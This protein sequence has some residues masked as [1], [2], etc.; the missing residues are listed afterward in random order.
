VG[1]TIAALLW[2]PVLAYAADQL[3]PGQVDA[4]RIQAAVA[5]GDDWLTHG[6][7][8]AEDRHSPL[9]DINAETVNRL[10]LAWSY[11]TGTKRGLEATPIVVD[12]VLYA[13]GSWS[14]VFA[15]DAR[16]GRE[17]WRFDPEVPKH[18]GRNACC[19]VVNRGVAVWKGRVYVGTIDGRL[20][21]IDSATGR[22]VW[23]VLTVDPDR[24]YTITGAPRVVKDLVI[25]GNGGADLGVRGYFGAYDAATGAL[26]WRFY[27]V[28]ANK[29]GPHEHPELVAAAKTWPANALWES[30]L[31]GTAWDSMAYDPELDLL[32]VGTGNSSVY[33]GAVRSPGGGDNLYLASILAL[34]PETGRLVWHYQTT[35]GENWDYTATQQMILTDR[36]Y[37]GKK[38]K[39]L[40]QAPK[41]G[42]FYILDR[43]TGEL[44]SAEPYVPVSWATHVDLE[45]GRPAV[46]EEADWSKEDRVIAPHVMGA[47]SWH[48]MSFDANRGLVY[49]SNFELAYL[50]MAD[51]NF[52]YRNGEYN[53]GEDMAEMAR[54]A[55]FLEPT[56]RMYCTPSRLVAWDIDRQQKRWEVERDIITAAGVLSTAG[57][58]VFQGTID[59]EF[60]AYHA[61]TGE[62]LWSTDT[63]VG[64]MAA[65][66][67][68]RVDGEQYVAVLAG[69]GGAVG[70]NFA[71]IR[72][73][74]EGT[75]LAFKLGGAVPM[76]AVH[77]R[78]AGRVTVAR[79]DASRETLDRG[80]SLYGKHCMRCHGPGV[81]SSGLLPD[82]R[83]ASRE[84]HARWT[85]V[86]L[87]GTRAKDGMASFAD[88]IDLEQAQ[89]IQ[90]YVIERAY[91]EP[92]ALE[93]LIAWLP[94][95]PFCVRSSWV[96]D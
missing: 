2:L 32:Y 66:V 53:S 6:R 28:P 56:N 19:D 83:H 46:R 74:N 49:M 79:I 48:P 22:P 14:V 54:L 69:A 85:D 25:I 44:L 60:S 13:T 65:P 87:G 90:S 59:G 29:N 10:G 20:I 52:E 23:D 72:N 68:Y 38:R 50:F 96:T 11:A 89:A 17:I 35:P 4:A 43:E 8:Y 7:T 67:T 1:C 34:R 75:L 15:L 42:F 64:I 55:E 9:R 61:D 31:G 63:G 16:T 30:G 47:H 39:L 73:T 58:L 40:L 77:A 95:S 93:T 45:T 78:P 76:P 24:P 94:E 26:R 3:A 37:R 86:V 81:V 51:S 84:V 33:N 70:G 27:T 41:N 12:G 91:H 5:Q 18:K 21:A 82:L 62:Q 71:R 36:V 57:D 92:S 80:R 88:L